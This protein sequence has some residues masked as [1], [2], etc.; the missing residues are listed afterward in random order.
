MDRVFRTWTSAGPM[1]PE[2]KPTLGDVLHI[3]GK[4]IARHSAK[5]AA[6]MANVNRCRDA[7]EALD[8]ALRGHNEP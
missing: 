8:S 7:Q 1:K 6:I 4:K 3:L 2:P 5:K